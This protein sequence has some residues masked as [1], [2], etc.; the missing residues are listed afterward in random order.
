MVDETRISRLL[1][2]QNITVENHA[3][4]THDYKL[5]DPNLKKIVEETNHNVG[6]ILI[7]WSLRHGYIPLPKT[8]PIERLLPNISVS[9]FELS[10]TIC[11]CWTILRNGSLPVGSVQTPHCFMVEYSFHTSQVIHICN[12]N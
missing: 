4:L 9:G 11:Q 3:P 7:R 8:K 12:N 10:G 2:D 1:Q 5:N 6:Q